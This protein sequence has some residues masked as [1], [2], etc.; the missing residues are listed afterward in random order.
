MDGSDRAKRARG[1]GGAKV[2]SFKGRN[3][4]SSYGL[5][6][7]E[8]SCETVEVVSLIVSRCIDDGMLIVDDSVRG[9]VTSERVMSELID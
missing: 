9:W 6:G 7:D 2:C 8:V 4:S 5:I 3:L 1:Q